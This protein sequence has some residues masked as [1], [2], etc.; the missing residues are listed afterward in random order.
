MYVQCTGTHVPYRVLY[1]TVHTCTTGTAAAV[2]Y[3][4]HFSKHT[5]SISIIVHVFTIHVLL[6]YLLHVP[7]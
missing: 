3:Y 2:I 5:C 1:S 7:S 6:S 4:T